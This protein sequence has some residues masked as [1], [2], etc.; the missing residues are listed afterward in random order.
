MEETKQ[1]V[2]ES[3]AEKREIEL[4]AQVRSSY[5]VIGKAL[6]EL[7]SMHAE[8]PVAEEKPVEEEQREEVGEKDDTEAEKIDEA[9]EEVKETESKEEVKEEK[10]EAVDDET[11]YY[12]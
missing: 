4:I 6:A 12:Y 3:T 9:E 5:D 11:K 10:S 1:E 7:E 2:Q 8:L